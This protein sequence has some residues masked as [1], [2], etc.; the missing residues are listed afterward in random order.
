MPW[1]CVDFCFNPETEAKG[2]HAVPFLKDL[3][4]KI[5]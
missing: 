1:W 3:M 4:D 5:L 2:K